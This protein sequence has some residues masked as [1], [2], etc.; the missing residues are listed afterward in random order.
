MACSAR[1]KVIGSCLKSADLILAR[2]H[3]TSARVGA[4]VSNRFAPRIDS[5]K[6]TGRGRRRERSA[7]ADPVFLGDLQLMVPLPARAPVI[8]HPLCKPPCIAMFGPDPGILSGLSCRRWKLR[9]SL[10]P[11]LPWRKSGPVA[12]RPGWS[13]G[14]GKLNDL[15]AHDCT[16]L[17]AAASVSISEQLL[18]ANASGSLFVISPA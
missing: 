2:F 16:A 13:R 7:V 14:G 18:S 1:T 6:R 4:G 11:P 8:L 15:A 12:H 3:A 9:L 17:A 10:A 5:L